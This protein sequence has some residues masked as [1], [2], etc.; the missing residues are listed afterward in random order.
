MKTLTKIIAFINQKGGVAK[1]TSSVNLAAALARLGFKVLLIDA[2][3]QANLTDNFNIVDPETT[4]YDLFKERPFS[5]INARENLDVIASTID[6]AGIDLEIQNQ[7]SR[8]KILGNRLEEIKQNYNYIIIDCPP[9]INLVTVNALTCSHYVVLPVKAASFS[10]KGIDKMLTFVGK[11]KQAINPD[12][13]ILG[14]LVSQYDEQLKISKSIMN[15]IKENG[16]NIALFDTKIRKNTAVENSQ[17]AHQTIFEYDDKCNAA[18]D[19]NSFTNEVLEKI[20]ND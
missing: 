4:I 1:T 5:P 20:K 3:K 19:Y 18:I 2:D 11:V 15:Q 9:D 7:I 14:I 6:F 8:E 13:S 12:L 17:Y 16:W 10:L